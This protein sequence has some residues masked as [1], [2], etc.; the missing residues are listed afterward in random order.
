MAGDQE[1]LEETQMEK[2]VC[3]GFSISGEVPLEREEEAEA[4]ALQQCVI[5]SGF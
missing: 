1:I 3:E 2:W 5:S 4:E